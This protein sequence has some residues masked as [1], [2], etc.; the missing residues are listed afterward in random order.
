MKPEEYL[1]A[2]DTIRKEVMSELKSTNDH[3]GAISADTAAIKKGTERNASDIQSLFKENNVH[4]RAIT[5]LD[6]N[7]KTCTARKISEAGILP[8]TTTDRGANIIA[9]VCGLTGVG[10]LIVA[11]IA[12][13]R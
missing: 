5:Q 10:A 1:S 9:I 6:T 8:G 4:A 13:F 12:L 11:L 7:Q 2:V 3:L